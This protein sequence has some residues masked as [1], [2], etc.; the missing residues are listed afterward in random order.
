M[1]KGVNCGKEECYFFSE[2]AGIE[3]GKGNTY[4]KIF[5]WLRWK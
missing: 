2:V 5:K 4:A 1:D 3:K